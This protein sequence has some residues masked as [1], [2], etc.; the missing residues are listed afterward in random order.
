MNLDDIVLRNVMSVEEAEL[1]HNN[2]N[3]NNNNNPSSSPP[4]SAAATAS[5]FLGKRAGDV[6]PQPDLM[7]EVSASTEGM[8]WMHYQR[9]LLIDSKLPASQAVYNN[10]G[11]VPDIGVYNLQ[12]MSITTSASSN[13][14]F[15]EGN[16]GRKR[17]QLD[18][19]KEKTIERRQRRMIK[20][21]ES[22]A[23][24][25]ARKQAY[26]N[27]LEHEVLCLRKT[28]SWLR[29]QEEVERMFLSNPIPMPRYQLRRTS[30]AF[31]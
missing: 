7:T 26:T 19:I 28:N 15:H 13:S 31:F 14:D 9:A 30:S 12:A 10:H 1:V 23:R 3:N 27:Q 8:E 4:A 21:R 24:S 25:R 17:R 20:N 5:L 29:K 2:N 11:S 6:E 18:D 22:A 16:S